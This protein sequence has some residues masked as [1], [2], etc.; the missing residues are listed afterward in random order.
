MGGETRFKSG[1][2]Q[3]MTKTSIS[4]PSFASSRIYC[5][6]NSLVLQWL[7][8]S[9][10]VEDTVYIPGFGNK[11]P[12]PRKER[13]KWRK[14]NL[15]LRMNVKRKTVGKGPLKTL[16]SGQGPIQR[17]LIQNRVSE[18]SQGRKGADAAPWWMSLSLPKSEVKSRSEVG[19]VPFLP[20]GVFLFVSFSG[21]ATQLV[22]S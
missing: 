4:N 22:G 13:I 20:S 9:S 18:P 14:H 12:R 6:G 5:R 11:M 7:Q 2:C 19:Q 8:L 16:F 10:T 17:Q 3:G 15:L 1:F 21:H